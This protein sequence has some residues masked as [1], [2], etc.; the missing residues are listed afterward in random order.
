M[1]SILGSTNRTPDKGQRKED[2]DAEGGNHICKKRTAHGQQA[3]A[4]HL[5]V[6]SGVQTNASKLERPN[7]GLLVSCHLPTN[8]TPY[9]SL[10]LPRIDLSKFTSRRHPSRTQLKLFTAHGSS[11]LAHNIQRGRTRRLDKLING[12]HRAR[13]RM[14]NKQPTALDN[15]SRS[16]KSTSGSGLALSI[17]MAQDGM[18]PL[19]PSDASDKFSSVV[20][21]DVAAWVQCCRRI[22]TRSHDGVYQGRTAPSRNS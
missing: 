4:V 8:N 16:G 3:G 17:P 6:F 5:T 10:K 21:R 15:F 2:K 19:R 12:Q 1:S 14:F 9:R 20:E 18:N 13:E 11:T 7:N 22:L